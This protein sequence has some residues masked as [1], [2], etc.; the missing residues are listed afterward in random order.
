MLERNKHNGFLRLFSKLAIAKM[1]SKGAF[2][3][4][5]VFPHGDFKSPCNQKTALH[6]RFLVVRHQGLEPGTP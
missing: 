3:Q 2:L 4:F 6:R 1:P 5:P